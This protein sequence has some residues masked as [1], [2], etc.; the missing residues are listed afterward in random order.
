MPEG[1][2]QNSDGSSSKFVVAVNTT[3]ISCRE[4]ISGWAYVLGHPY[5]GMLHWKCRAWVP[6]SGEWPHDA[7]A[8]DYLGEPEI[9]MQQPNELADG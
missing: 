5:H 6:N 4:R 7:P 9:L 3:C 1:E 2:R 8:V